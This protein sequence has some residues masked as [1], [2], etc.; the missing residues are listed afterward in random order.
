MYKTFSIKLD[1]VQ[2]AKFESLKKRFKYKDIQD[3]IVQ[4]LEQQYSNIR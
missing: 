4:S 1:Q 3:F 2:L